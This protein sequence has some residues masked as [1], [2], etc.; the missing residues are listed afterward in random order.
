[1]LVVEVGPEQ[2]EK[3]VS[4]VERPRCGCGQ[5]GEQGE[6]LGLSQDSVEQTV[7]AA[8]KIDRSQHR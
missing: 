8:P 2:G 7:I 3:G 1:M 4:R 5:V 6:P